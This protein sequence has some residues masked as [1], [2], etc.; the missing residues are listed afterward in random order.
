[1]DAEYGMVMPFFI[2]TAGYTDRDREMF[3]CGVEWQM[4]YDKIRSGE[5]FNCTIHSEN[6]SRIR[7]MAGRLGRQ[8]LIE[9]SG[10]PGWS[11]LTV[12]LR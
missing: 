5:R 8:V 4:V 3:V 9:D 2:D 11:Y 7:M 1:M 6:E 12:S 10:V